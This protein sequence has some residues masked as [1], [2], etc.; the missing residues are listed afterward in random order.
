M[1]LAMLFPFN[2]PHL[3]ICNT[4]CQKNSPGS[5]HGSH[6]DE[7][8][9]DVSSVKYDVWHIIDAQQM[10]VPHPSYCLGSFLKHKSVVMADKGIEF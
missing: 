10:L 7:M 9:F 3:L 2:G 4:G 1:V 8:R 5:S 6:K